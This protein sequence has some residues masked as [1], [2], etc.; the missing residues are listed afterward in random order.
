MNLGIY[1][2]YIDTLIDHDKVHIF[3]IG[4]GLDTRYATDYRISGILPDIRT[5]PSVFKY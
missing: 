5:D 4:V 2:L 3:Y 1:I